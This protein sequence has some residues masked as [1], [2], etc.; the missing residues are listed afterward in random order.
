MRTRSAAQRAA[1][2]EGQSM[3]QLVE[4]PPQLPNAADNTPVFKTTSIQ[5]KATKS[6]K[7]TK[8][9]RA[10]GQDSNLDV[11]APKRTRQSKRAKAAKP[12]LPA[13][14][15]PHGLGKIHTIQQN[16]QEEV[17]LLA[18]SA[19]VEKL[20]T[21]PDSP[22]YLL[23]IT[24]NFVQE[25][26]EKASSSIYH[27][28]KPTTPTAAHLSPPVDESR[29]RT[30]RT[31]SHRTVPTPHEV[32]LPTPDASFTESVDTTIIENLEKETQEVR[33]KKKKREARRTK[34]NPYGLMPGRTPFPDLAGPTEDACREVHRI[35]TETHGEF[36]APDKIPAPSTS[37]AG[38]GE[39]PDLVDALIRTLIS[40]HTAMANANLAIQDVIAKY[41]QWGPESVGAGS[42][43]W[44][45]VRLSDE[46]EIVQAVKRAGLGPTKGK[47]IK[48]ILEQVYQ[49]NQERKAAYF[50]EKETGETTEMSGAQGLTQG[51]KDH[52]LLKIENGV[53]T[54][55]HIRGMT[56]NE[57]M[58]EFTKYPG[59]GVKTASCLVLFCLQQPSFAV[60]T[61]VWRFC[62]WLG[63]VPP[64]ASRD[65]TYM[66]GEVRIPNE[67]KYGLHQLF[68]RHGKECGR[69]RSGTVEGTREWDELVCPL[70]HL[71]DR[72][73][74]RKTKMQSKPKKAG[75]KGKA[76]I[77]DEDEDEE[78]E[79][80]LP[81]E[82]ETMPGSDAEDEPND[83][84]E[85]GGVVPAEDDTSNEEPRDES[86]KT[87]VKEAVLDFE[88]NKLVVGLR[89]RKRVNYSKMV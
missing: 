2:A 71:L 88:T 60:D 7:A 3:A 44:N 82:T 74:K 32:P 81:Q 15:L 50:K 57:A 67:L 28:I 23:S 56:P 19:G 30:L 8:K 20:D 80:K 21:S 52:Q 63:W 14:I 6:V 62:K 53:L 12:T 16:V 39:V 11:P 13:D 17:H 78:E 61:H 47:D 5:V 65:D 46:A 9:K 75:K 1:A 69:C 22:D 31:R 66:H 58:L 49:D 48:L 4:P 10:A 85:I 64:K 42:I 87:I 84:T 26:I 33:V 43:D 54:L 70:E 45:K 77:E 25:I 55:D 79:Q 36:K 73:D 83:S 72:F 29:G 51:Q 35:L 18:K 89:L 86:V 76:K 27:E 24:F 68:I 38:C 34:A 40:G 37:V 59:I 41:G